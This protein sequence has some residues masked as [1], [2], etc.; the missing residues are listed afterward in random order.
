MV[1]KYNSMALDFQKQSENLLQEI[2][3]GFKQAMEASKKNYISLQEGYL[4]G[5][6]DIVEQ[7]KKGNIQSYLFLP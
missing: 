5:Y 2:T 4:K 3:S 1:A 7:A 6:N